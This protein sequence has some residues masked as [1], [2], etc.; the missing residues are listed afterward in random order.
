MT[1][2]IVIRVAARDRAKAW[3]LL[4]KH[5]PGTALPN[6][7]FIVSEQAAQALKEAGVRFTEITR[8]PGLPWTEGT[9]TG[10]RI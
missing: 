2:R 6:R 7:T 1:M 3:E 4:V 9:L 5:S 10:E 8:E